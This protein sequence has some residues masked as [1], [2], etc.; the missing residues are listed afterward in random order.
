MKRSTA[1][2]IVVLNLAVTALPAGVASSVSLTVPEYKVERIGNLD[3][4]VIPG[5]RQL[6]VEA[7]RPQVPYYDTVL[8][9]PK[10]YRIQEVVMKERT[11]MK[12]DSGL[13]LPAVTLPRYDDQIETKVPM[14]SGV[15]PLDDYG[16]EALYNPDG[17]AALTITAYPFYYDPG[18]TRVTFYR[19]YRFD[20]RY[21]QTE[22]EVTQVGTDKQVYD[23]GAK[24]TATIKLGNSGKAQ[25]V[26]AGAIVRQAF[27]GKRIADIP[28]KVV[29]RLGKADS[30]ALE[31]PTA[32]F[33]AGDYKFDIT[34]RDQAGNELDRARV[35][36]RLGDPQ[37]EV[38]GFKA[39]PQ[40]FR[41]G[42]RIRFTLDFKNRGT[43]DLAGAGV[44]RIM[45]AGE[46]VDE[47][48]QDLPMLKPNSSVSLRDSWDSKQ[49]EKGAIYSAVGYASYEGTVCEPKSVTFSTNL[50]P[51]ASFAAT[52]DTQ[53][54]GK[55][56]K[57]DA[58]GSRDEDGKI[59]NYFWEFD[60][61]VTATGSAAAHAFY[62]PGEHS[63]TLTVTDNEAGTGT[64]LRIVMV[65]N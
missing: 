17:T 34:V 54:V 48:E 12:Q 33:P 62:D 31:W 38:T 36:F 28:A 6:T 24:V 1:L 52:P 35:M 60:D 25:D 64:A 19:N 37:G 3:E 4:V 26:A 59:V 13:K 32:G 15:Y 14:K 58:T 5:G 56:I 50:T 53:S 65:K 22:V 49:A 63:V 16:W 40:H 20:I 7:G 27:T 23:P 55:E 10:G 46:M 9:Y 8:D 29:P 43:C 11:G 18:T 42:D 51:L 30:I 45:K 57:F 47:L 21:V 2:V 41:I 39:E 44:I 61:G